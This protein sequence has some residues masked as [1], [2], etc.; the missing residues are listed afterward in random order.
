[1]FL[2]KKLMIQLS[3]ITDMEPGQRF[4]ILAYDLKIL[5]SKPP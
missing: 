2:K 3:V 1:M 4:R 5:L